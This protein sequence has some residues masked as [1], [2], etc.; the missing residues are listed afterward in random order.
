MPADSDKDQ[1]VLRASFFRFLD[2]KGLVRPPGEFPAGKIEQDSLALAP[3]GRALPKLTG[4]AVGYLALDHGHGL[5]ALREVVLT[6]LFDWQGLPLGGLLVGFPVRDIAPPDG[7]KHPATASGIWLDGQIYLNRSVPAPD[8][9]LLAAR[10]FQATQ[11]KESGHLMV[12]FESGPQMAFYKALDR[13]QQL[14]PAYEV[15]LYP[16]EKALSRRAALRW[17]VVGWG[18]I[19]LGAGLVLSLLLTRRLSKPVEKI[20]AGSVENLTRRRQAEQE[21]REA[22]EQLTRVLSELK[23]SHEDMI[24]D[25]RWRAAG[26]KLRRSCTVPAIFLHLSLGLPTCLT[27]P[28]HLSWD[29]RISC[30]NGRASSKT[31][32]KRS[33]SSSSFEPQPRMPLVL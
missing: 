5:E 2:D 7:G 9:R 31:P 32:P 8:Y 12:K 33:N 6:K 15:C 16:L 21:L 26:E 11:E 10:L 14:E 27:I 13:D 29:L 23:V 4:Q 24:Q 17:K 25:K 18:A 28:L 3:A 20:V 1:Q 30:S 22:N 19:V